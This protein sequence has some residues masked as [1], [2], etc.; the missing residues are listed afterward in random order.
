M[1]HVML[2][3][4]KYDGVCIM[5]YRVRVG[6]TCTEVCFSDLKCHR[7]T[8]P[9]TCRRVCVCVSFSL[10]TDLY[11]GPALLIS[12][13]GV[14]WHAYLERSI[15]SSISIKDDPGQRSWSALPVVSASVQF[16]FCVQRPCTL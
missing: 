6:L 10:L 7:Q 9:L 13:V 16:I 11:Q 1:S 5:W 2:L 12:L 15:S 14:G 8:F 4:Y 3:P